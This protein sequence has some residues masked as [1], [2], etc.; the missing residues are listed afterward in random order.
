MFG[1]FE[2]FNFETENEYYEDCLYFGLIIA[3]SLHLTVDTCIGTYTN[4]GLKECPYSLYVTLCIRTLKIMF[5]SLFEN[6]KS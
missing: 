1:V 4:L 2:I 5:Q 6:V 3:V